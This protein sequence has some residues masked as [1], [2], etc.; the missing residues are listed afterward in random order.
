MVS[1]SSELTTETPPRPRRRIPH[2][3]Q[4]VLGL[5]LGAV[6]GLTANALASRAPTPGVADPYDVDGNGV[7]DRLDWW[8][9]NVADPLGKVFLRLIFM[10]VI[11]L[12]FS[13]LALGA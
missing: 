1:T 8:A 12:V 10:V 4:I 9:I 3:W 13:A 11:P 2:H 7:H 6:V 5:I